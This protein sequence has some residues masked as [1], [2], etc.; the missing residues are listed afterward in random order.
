VADIAAANVSVAFRT[1]DGNKVHVCL[2]VKGDGA[3]VT[4]PVPLGRIE[5]HM[6]GVIDAAAGYN[7][8]ITYSGNIVTYAV[9][10]IINVYHFLHLFGTD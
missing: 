6:V 5:A 8:A 4:I 3:G 7:P 10:P 2:K 9:A 1:L